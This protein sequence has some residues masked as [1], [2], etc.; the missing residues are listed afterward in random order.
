MGEAAGGL[1][2]RPTTTF[3][4]VAAAAYKFVA[5]TII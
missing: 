3:N 1:F 2:L 4:F 5:A